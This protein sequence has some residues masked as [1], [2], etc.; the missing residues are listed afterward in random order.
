MTAIFFPLVLLALAEILR[1]TQKRYRNT[2]KMGSKYSSQYNMCKQTSSIQGCWW[3]RHIQQRHTYIYIYIYWSDNYNNSK[4]Q[5]YRIPFVKELGRGT[6]R[7]SMTT[8]L[9]KIS[10]E[11]GKWGK[12]SKDKHFG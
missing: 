6:S 12:D 10:R 4:G 8:I 9:E 7:I 2:H 5:I 11:N 1:D 3:D